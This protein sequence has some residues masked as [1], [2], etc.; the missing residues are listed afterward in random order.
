MGDHES[1]NENERRMQN[2]EDRLS[3]IASDL[4]E[5]MSILS[6][7]NDYG[8]RIKAIETSLMALQVGAGDGSKH[9]NDG[10][11]FD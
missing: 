4:N 6:W 3:D 9:K 2:I 7:R 1:K 11:W 10:G 5:I 8:D